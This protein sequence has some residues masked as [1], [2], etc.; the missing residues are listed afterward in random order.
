MYKCDPIAKEFIDLD[1]EVM[2]YISK[3]KRE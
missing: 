1:E 3:A 2:E